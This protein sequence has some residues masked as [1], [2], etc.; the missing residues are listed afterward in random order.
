MA[1][2]ILYDWLVGQSCYKLCDYI[3]ASF[4]PRGGCESVTR[5]VRSHLSPNME[6]TYIISIPLKLAKI[7]SCVGC[8]CLLRQLPRDIVSVACRKNVVASC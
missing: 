6:V 5:K 3:D 7:V 8:V 2:V 1:G 4:A